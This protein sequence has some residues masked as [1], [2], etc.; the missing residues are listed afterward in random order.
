MLS[1]SVNFE[2]IRETVQSFYFVT[3]MEAVSDAN[4]LNSDR[5]TVGCVRSFAFVTDGVMD[6]PELARVIHLLRDYKKL[7]TQ[8]HNLRSTPPPHFYF[9][10][11]ISHLHCC[12]QDYKLDVTHRSLDVRN[13]Y[14]AFQLQ[15]C[16]N[17][18]ALC[19]LAFFSPVRR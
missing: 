4:V 1:T 5:H 14:F 9:I 10:L 18:F 11:F 15:I 3:D 13:S 17:I 12:C 8:C 2:K 19:F 16:V 7:N 6:H